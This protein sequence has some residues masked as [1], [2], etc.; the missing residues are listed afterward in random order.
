MYAVFNINIYIFELIYEY[1]AGCQTLLYI[2]FAK[3]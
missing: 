3:I 1:Q 2:F